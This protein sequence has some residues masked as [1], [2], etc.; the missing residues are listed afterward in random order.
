MCV[1]VAAVVVV[2]V[3]FLA[4][5]FE[6]ISAIKRPQMLLSYKLLCISISCAH[7]V[8]KPRKPLFKITASGKNA[9][10]RAVFVYVYVRAQVGY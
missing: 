10:P 8:P 4:A 1:V 6:S 7:N 3:M 2:F 5:V 9:V